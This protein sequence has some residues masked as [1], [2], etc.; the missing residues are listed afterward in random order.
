MTVLCGG[1]SSLDVVDIA[2][3]K[4]KEKYKMLFGAYAFH[5]VDEQ[6]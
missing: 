3:G 2:E 4:V 1:Q 6:D 5:A